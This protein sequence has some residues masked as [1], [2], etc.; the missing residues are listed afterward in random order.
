MEGLPSRGRLS[1]VM[2]H[3]ADREKIGDIELLAI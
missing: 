2:V 1:V 3:W